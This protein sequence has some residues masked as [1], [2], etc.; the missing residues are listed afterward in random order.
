MYEMET[1][2]IFVAKKKNTVLRCERER[3]R[4]GTRFV[5]IANQSVIL[6]FV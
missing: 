1:C 4:E 3:E 2:T 6:L 5:V